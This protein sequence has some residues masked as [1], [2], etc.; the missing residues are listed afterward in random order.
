MWAPVLLIVLRFAQGLAIGGQWAGAVL[1]ATENAPPHKRGF[2]GAFPQVGAPAGLI[3]ANLMFLLVNNSVS[4]EAFLSWGWRIPF[5]ASILLI[6]LAVY[7]QLT[8]EDTAEFR[9]LQRAK[10][11]KNAHAQQALDRPQQSPVLEA[12]K[13]YPR[14]IALAA[15]ALTA[16]QVSFYILT[17]FL[18]AYGTNPAGLN[19]PRSTMLIAVL[20]S[21]VLMIPALLI[22]AWISDRHGRRGIFITGAALMGLWGFVLFPMI[23]TGMF[24]WIVVGMSVSQIFFGMMYGPQATFLSEIFGTRVRYSATSL[25]YQIGA[26]VGGAFAPIIATAL[27]AQFQTGF[28]VAVY[29]A[30]ACGVTILSAILLTRK[31][32]EVREP[33]R[34]G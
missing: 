33:M 12:L 7:V 3:A 24:I 28:A 6:M 9:E 17:T 5:V 18:L 1:L 15:G 2:Y 34:I 11:Q 25:G 27:V 16:I 14:E 22:S 21:A 29:I 10:A 20:M 31:P 30:F 26:I 8:I 19:L 23:D 32:G 13:T 4:P